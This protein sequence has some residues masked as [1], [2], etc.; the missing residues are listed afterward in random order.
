MG[1]ERFLSA[2]EG[3]REATGEEI[4]HREEDRGGD[5]CDAACGGDRGK[6]PVGGN[7]RGA[8]ARGEGGDSEVWDVRQDKQGGSRGTEPA[9]RGSHRD[10]GVEFSFVQGVQS[11]E[12]RGRLI[13]D[14]GKCDIDGAAENGNADKRKKRNVDEGP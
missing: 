10:T 3:R 9:H 2:A 8:G 11:A 12:G 4:G 14:M 5:V 6:H 1:R 13:E 7:R